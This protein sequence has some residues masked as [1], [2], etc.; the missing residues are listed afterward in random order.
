M[1]IKVQKAGINDD[2]DRRCLGAGRDLGEFHNS[3][4]GF[5][6]NHHSSV[7]YTSA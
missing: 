1:S 6:C 4:V 3:L 5:C 7:E 2:T